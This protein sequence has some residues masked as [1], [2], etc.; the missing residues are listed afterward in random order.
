M[1][2][3]LWK[4]ASCGQI[5]ANLGHPLESASRNGE[6]TL[7]RGKGELTRATAWR[8]MFLTRRLTVL[9]LG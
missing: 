5:K 4:L 9:D 6:G 3:S 2:T 1:R 7:R 8:P